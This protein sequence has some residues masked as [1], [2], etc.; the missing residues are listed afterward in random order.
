MTGFDYS[1]ASTLVS[2]ISAA[3]VSILVAVR[4]HV[5]A[6]KVEQIREQVQTP[7]D[8]TLG[9]TVAHVHEVVC[10]DRT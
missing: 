8:Q 6:P 7:G 5:M 3:V 9:E 4:Q 10:D 2:A 1:G